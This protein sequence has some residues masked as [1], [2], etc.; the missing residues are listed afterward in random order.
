MPNIVNKLA[1]AE[2]TDAFSK[3]EGM[4]FFEMSGLTMVE[5]E[6]LRGAIFEQGAELRMVRNR[7][8][9]LA[10]SANGF[11]VGRDTFNGNVAIA[12]GNAEATIGAAKAV[13]ESKL[14]KAGKIGVRGGVLEGSVLGAA[15]AAALANVPDR[16]T[17]R[18]MLLGAISAPARGLAMVINGN[19]SG[20]AR[21][22]Q[23]RIDS[24]GDTEA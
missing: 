22:I 6:T 15:D 5:N 18:A 9:V 14:K 11:E 17:L 4:L 13:G 7:L 16:L 2:L 24:E 20:L 12:W 8:A 21:L 1:Y 3:A 19:Q 23:A 10:L